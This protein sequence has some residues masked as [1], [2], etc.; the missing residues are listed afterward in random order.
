MVSDTAAGVIGLVIAVVA[1]VNK[2]YNSV[3]WLPPLE[4]TSA[5]HK[6]IRLVYNDEGMYS[7]SIMHFS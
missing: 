2:P 5:D 3:W 6:T 4:K 1:T 7:P